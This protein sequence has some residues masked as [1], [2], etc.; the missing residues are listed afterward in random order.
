MKFIGPSSESIRLMGDKVQARRA[1]RKVKVPT[2]PG[3]DGAITEEEE[4]LRI[5]KEIG[6]PA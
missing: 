5:A 4:G 6:F 1:V 2:V 3:S